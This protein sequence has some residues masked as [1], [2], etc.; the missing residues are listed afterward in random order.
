VVAVVGFV[1][2]KVDYEH[3]YWDQAS[4]LLQVGLLKKDGLPVTG[5]EQAQKLRDLRASRPASQAGTQHRA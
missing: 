4:L 1:D 2:G 5:A 3:L